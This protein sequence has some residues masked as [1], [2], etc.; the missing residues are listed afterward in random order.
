MDFAT[1][2]EFRRITLLTDRISEESQRF[3]HRFGF[4][5]SHM[6]PMRLTLS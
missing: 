1:K 6:V 2:K 5:Q 4:K 3:F